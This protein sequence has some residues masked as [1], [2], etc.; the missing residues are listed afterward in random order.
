MRYSSKSRPR[1]RRLP[2][3]RP[4]PRSNR[5]CVAPK[6]AAGHRSATVVAL[7]V[8]SRLLA[9]ASP[10]THTKWRSCRARP[11][12]RR[13]AVSVGPRCARG[14]IFAGKTYCSISF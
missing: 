6:C 14:Q 5:E 8:P 9:M 7:H 3:R 11:C 4:P 12:A 10:S 1:P 13:G 2:F